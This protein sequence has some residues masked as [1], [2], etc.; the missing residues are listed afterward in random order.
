MQ[1]NID[2]DVSPVLDRSMSVKEAGQKLFELIVEV[3][4]GYQTA[5]ELLG[6][7]EFA[8]HRVALTT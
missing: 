2:F 4:N 1:E 7:Y 6:H 8:L 5:S 3:A